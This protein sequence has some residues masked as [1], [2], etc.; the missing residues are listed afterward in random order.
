M[1][2]LKITLIIATVAISLA[3]TFILH[4]EAQAKLREND[5]ALHRQDEQL[6]ELVAEQERLSNQVAE[7]KNSTNSQ[8]SELATLRSQ[9]HA[10][11]KQIN[12]PAGQLRSNR[13]ARAPQP[14]TKPE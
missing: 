2:K 10:L 12:E 5:A 14:A 7:A 13:Q 1:T 8:L 3:V 11:Q 4:R 9:A 6:N